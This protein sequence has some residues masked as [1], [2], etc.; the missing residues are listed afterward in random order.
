MKMSNSIHNKLLLGATI[1]GAGMFSLSCQKKLAGKRGSSS[2]ASLNTTV[3]G[4]IAEGSDPARLCSYI[5]DKGYFPSNSYAANTKVLFSSSYEVVDNSAGQ[6]YGVIGSDGYFEQ[7]GNTT[8]Q[9]LLCP[10]APK[11]GQGRCL[12]KFNG[13]DGYAQL[14]YDVVCNKRSRTGG[15]VHPGYTRQSAKLVSYVGNTAGQSVSGEDAVEVIMEGRASKARIVFAKGTGLVA[16]LFQESLQPAGTAEVFIGAGGSFSGGGDN[17]GSGG[18]Q[19]NGSD[20]S[21]GQGSGGSSNS[22]SS[23][24]NSVDP[25]ADSRYLNLK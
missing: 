25:N 19:N 21:N 4:E 15:S 12:W 24:D 6:G 7:Q 5:K 11:N 8:T 3:K 20:G 14:A 13:S 23:Q 9:L 16:T 10:G 17:Q 2:L 1:I 18:S 22:G